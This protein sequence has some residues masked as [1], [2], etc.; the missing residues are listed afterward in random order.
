V[1]DDDLYARA[2]ATL[3]ASWER[4]ARG[5]AGAALERLDGVSAA[6]FP[7][8]PE[9]G[10]YNNALLDRGLGG[11]RRAAAVDAMQAAYGAAG[12]ARY[13]AWVNE[14]D[15]GM[16]AE[17]SARGYT[18][19]ES[20]R[21]MGMSLD[22][23]SVAL[24]EVELEPLDWA[25]YLRYLRA[26]GLPAGLLG[27]V[28]PSAFHIL[29]ARLAGVDVATALAFDHDGDCGVLSVSTLEAARGR[30]L[31][32]ALTARHLRDAVERACSTASVVSTAMA[33]RIYAAVG[34]RD[35]GR[36]LEYVP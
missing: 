20:N 34:F 10:I 15:D 16:R 30:G 4:Y 32:T 29:V 31:A 11:A 9:R 6:V 3:V 26:F 17:L 2:A 18:I 13:A 12:I 25:G 35:L 7:S 22:D 21:A 28:D 24:P 8:H 19:H 23:L 14:S 5:S 1:T 33:E 27:G 36:F